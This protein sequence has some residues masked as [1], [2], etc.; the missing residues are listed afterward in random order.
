MML[1]MRQRPCLP[2]LD[3]QTLR[4]QGGEGRDGGGEEGHHC[5]APDCTLQGTERTP[6]LIMSHCA[7][8]VTSDSGKRE[9]SC[10]A[11]LNAHSD[12]QPR[13]DW[14][15]GQT[16]KTCRKLNQQQKLLV[17]GCC[18]ISFCELDCIV[19]FCFFQTF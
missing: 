9:V 18:L 8:A 2:K 5:I 6:L 19:C 16:K 1:G 15:I 14:S 11:E 17:L 3:F 12:G 7:F 4:N 13:L 10:R